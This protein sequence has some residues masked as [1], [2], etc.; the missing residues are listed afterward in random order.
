[1]ERT[2]GAGTPNSLV[3]E[4]LLARNTNEN[5]TAS[6]P[7]S[8]EVRIRL[9]R[10]A[11]PKRVYVLASDAE[12]SKEKSATT[13]QRRSL[14]FVSFV[15][16]N[17][18]V[19]EADPQLKDK[20]KSMLSERQDV[21]RAAMAQEL[22]P[23]NEQ[24]KEHLHLVI[25][26]TH[27]VTLIWVLWLCSQPMACNVDDNDSSTGVQVMAELVLGGTLGR[28]GFAG[29]LSYCIKCECRLCGV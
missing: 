8:K 26:M 27:P 29:M 28:Y 22:Q 17:K 12:P 4:H 7:G 11:R 21:N 2:T 13:G 6:T 25:E 9:R 14:F 23:K 19:S 16:P 24:H 3:Y 5:I 10:G 20:L 15:H 1:M 18:H